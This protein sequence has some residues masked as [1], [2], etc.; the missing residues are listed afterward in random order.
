[1]SQTQE[2]FHTEASNSSTLSRRINFF[3]AVGLQWLPKWQDYYYRASRELCSNYLS[4]FGRIVPQEIWNEQMH[5][6][7]HFVSYIC[8]VPC[9]IWQRF[10]WHTVGPERQIWSLQ[11][12]VKLPHRITKRSYYQSKCLTSCL[13]VLTQARSRPRYTHGRLPCRRQVGANQTRSCSDQ[14]PL[15][16]TFW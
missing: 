3:I 5:S 12:K 13:P 2:V 11:I 1:M 16:F 9:K 15:K 4:D 14:A 7:P 10:L 8:T 6:P